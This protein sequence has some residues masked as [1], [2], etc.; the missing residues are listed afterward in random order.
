VTYGVVNVSNLDV[1]PGDAFHRTHRT[2]I[3][4][5][6]NPIPLA[7]IVL[8]FLAGT[9]VNKNGER[10]SASQFQAGWTLKY[11]HAAVKPQ[12]W[13]GPGSLLTARRALITCASINRPARY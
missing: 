11:W 10:A 12:C 3:N 9:R 13:V 2:S 7:D 4:L 8:E 5:T 6:W 1:Q